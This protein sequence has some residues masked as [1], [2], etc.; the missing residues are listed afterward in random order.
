MPTFHARRSLPHT[1]PA[2]VF[3]W[4]DR[5]G[6]FARLTPPWVRT[7]LD[8]PPRGLF[9][10]EHARFRLRLLGCSLPWD[11]ETTEVTPGRG[12]VDVA[13]RAPFARWNHRH[14]FDADGAAVL[15]DEVDWEALVPPLGGWVAGRAIE[16]DLRRM[17]VWRHD[18]TERDLASHARYADRPRLRVGI[19]GASGLVGRELS[20]FLTT[21]GHTVVPF[22]RT[23]GVP[24]TIAWDP[25]A[26]T[27][28]PD[29]LAGLDAIAHLAGEPIAGRW[30]PT[31]RA[32]IRRSRVEGTALL[33]RALA[34]CPRPPA[35]LIS[36]SAVGYFG[37]HDGPVVEGDPPGSGFLAEVG[38]AWEAAAD[39]ARAAGLRVV[40]PR[41]AVVMSGRGGALP[42]MLPAFR[43]GLGGPLGSGTQA[44][45]WID[46]DDLVEILHQALW[47]TS[48]EG[49]IHAAAPEAVDQRT[50][51]R[52]LGATL[53]RPAVLPVP[54]ALLRAVG[55]EMAQ[56][57]LLEGAQT[58]PAFLQARG[59]AWRRPTLAESLRAQLG[60]LGPP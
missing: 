44:F 4:H 12:F 30:T 1:T 31:R 10:G 42:A 25:R 49:P 40:H 9:V 18:T 3:A 37:H 53:R 47:E 35:T 58:V 6:A 48:W 16:Q 50:F 17:F 33:A 14:T 55:G 39:P 56:A 32:E 45:P 28:D 60:V 24:G 46:L 21:G 57:V 13:R 27:L 59:F 20:A 26:G 41:I 19:T 52:T 5:P 22:T 36:A 8:E 15:D 23:S 54:A 34:A 2:D 29:A 43:L 7:T 51:A 38:A 11:A